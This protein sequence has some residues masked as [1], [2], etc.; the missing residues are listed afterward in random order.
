ME[1]LTDNVNRSAAEVRQA[2]AKG[3]GKMADPNSVMFN[4]QRQGLI[5]I[6]SAA[7]EDEVSGADRLAFLPWH[8]CPLRASIALSAVGCADF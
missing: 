4:F 5:F 1:C 6:D 7:G 2:V 3:G 8:S